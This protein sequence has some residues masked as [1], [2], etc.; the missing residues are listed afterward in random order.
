MQKKLSGDW[1]PV[2]QMRCGA[3][4]VWRLSV[5]ALGA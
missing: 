2:E 1:A 4:C 5:F 3:S